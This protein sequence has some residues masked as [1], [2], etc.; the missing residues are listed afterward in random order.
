MLL[1]FFNVA[2]PPIDWESKPHNF[3]NLRFSDFYKDPATFPDLSIHIMPSFN[4]S[5]LF[6][7][8]FI[9]CELA[10]PTPQVAIPSISRVPRF[11]ALPLV[12]SQ[13][14]SPDSKHSFYGPQFGWQQA[15]QNPQHPHP[16]VPSVGSLPVDLPLLASLPSLP[17]LRGMSV[18]AVGLLAYI[19]NVKNAPST[20]QNSVGSLPVNVPSI[21]NTPSVPS[22][23]ALP[24]NLPN[25][26]T[27]APGQG[28]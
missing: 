13:W 27:L 15:C 22:A 1:Q 8:V 12:T 25:L 16:G 7:F 19:S 20:V 21:P 24:V 4:N 18:P 2:I 6:S 5:A 26:A 9:A 17:V 23:A 28:P 3:N 10:L 11:D 14:I